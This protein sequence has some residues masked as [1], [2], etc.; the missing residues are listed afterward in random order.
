MKAKI[1]P[2][3]LLILFLLQPAVAF[4]NTGSSNPFGF[5]FPNY[6]GIGGS[7]VRED[8]QKEISFDDTGGLN[9]KL[10]FE[11]YQ[12]LILE[13]DFDYFPQFEGKGT[14]LEGSQISNQKEERD[15][16]NFM[17]VLKFPLALSHPLIR[18]SLLFGMGA[19]YSITDFQKNV[20]S[21]SVSKNDGETGLSLKFGGSLEITFSDHIV[22]GGEGAFIQLIGGNSKTE[23][24]IKFFLITFWVAY[25]F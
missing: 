6:A 1:F 4:G 24:K 2:F 19:F 12:V 14:V 13:L 16:L 21:A 7:F 8:F 10:G 5:L 20:G 18:P 25:R 9:L 22:I 11:F 3:F 23:D 15:I 17:A